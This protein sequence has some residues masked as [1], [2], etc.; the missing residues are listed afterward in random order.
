MSRVHKTE[1]IEVYL[2][3]DAFGGMT[4]T[5]KRKLFKGKGTSRLVGCV[6]Q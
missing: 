6:S 2:N 1:E 4:E 3:G 5:L